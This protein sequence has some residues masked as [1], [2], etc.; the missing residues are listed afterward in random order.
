MCKSGEGIS[1]P[2][3]YCGEKTTRKHPP[4]TIYRTSL[5]S[6]TMRESLRKPCYRGFYCT[7]QYNGQRRM[8]TKSYRPCHLR[9]I[10]CQI[11]AVQMTSECYCGSYLSFLSCIWDVCIYTRAPTNV[12]FQVIKILIEHELGE[13]IKSLDRKFR[14]SSNSIDPNDEDS[15]L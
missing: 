12:V 3:F 4:T 9:F 8:T 7:E 10:R 14:P 6:R 5:L 15:L 13:I 11:L 1:E 2:F